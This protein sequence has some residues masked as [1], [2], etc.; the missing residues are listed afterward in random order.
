LVGCTPGRVGLKMGGPSGGKFRAN[1]HSRVEL[2]E[3]T[4]FCPA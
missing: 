3:L 4:V 1:N 2:Y